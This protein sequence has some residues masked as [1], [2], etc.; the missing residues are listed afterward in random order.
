MCWSSFCKGCD[1]APVIAVGLEVAPHREVPHGRHVVFSWHCCSWHCIHD[2]VCD[3]VH[4]W[5]GHVHACPGP[6]PPPWL[7]PTVCHVPYCSA[8][9]KAH[10]TVPYCAVCGSLAVKGR[11]CPLLYGT[12]HSTA[13][14][15]IVCRI[16]L[17][18]PP[19]TAIWSDSCMLAPCRGDRIAQLHAVGVYDSG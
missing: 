17:P 7:L 19:L 5:Y 1:G 10:H 9:T 2:H 3:V 4:V 13:P 14:P 12:G 6:M 8:T 18:S 15:C 11:C 16:P